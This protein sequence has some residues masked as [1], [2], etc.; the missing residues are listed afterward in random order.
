MYRQYYVNAYFVTPSSICFSPRLLLAR[1]YCHA[2]SV[3]LGLL[4]IAPLHL[5]GIHPCL[6]LH[7]AVDAVPAPSARSPLSLP[8]QQDPG[9]RT[10]NP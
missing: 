3:Y 7:G 8:N 1:L 4:T 9:T 5:A 2:S 10:R 6:L